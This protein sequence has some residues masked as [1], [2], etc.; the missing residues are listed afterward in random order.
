[1]ELTEELTEELAELTEPSP[2]PANDEPHGEVVEAAAEAG[3]TTSIE[4]EMELDTTYTKDDDD[5]EGCPE[6]GAAPTESA[7]AVCASPAQVSEQP[8][9]AEAPA[10][11]VDGEDDDDVDGSA[12]VTGPPGPGPDSDVMDAS[13]PTRDGPP[14]ARKMWKDSPKVVP[15]P[16]LPQ[17]MPQ[18]W[19][20]SPS[21]CM[22]R[23]RFLLPA[24]EYGTPYML[25]TPL[26]AWY[27]LP[28]RASRP[29]WFL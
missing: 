29:L 28:V 5:G 16:P 14:K 18:Q 11:I 22:S 4:A 27:P 8:A 13:S 7:P 1:M 24:W 23:H 25:G 20:G 3:P 21:P 2:A 12:G 6:D 15:P 19:F 10:A 17:S 9:E 26:H